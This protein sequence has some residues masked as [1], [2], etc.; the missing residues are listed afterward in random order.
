MSNV[1]KTG[2][3]SKAESSS[4][5]PAFSF[6]TKLAAGVCGLVLLTGAAAAWFSYRG[7]RA[8]TNALVHSMFREV[9]GH[10]V[11]HTRAFVMRAAPLAESLAQLADNGLAIHDS[12]LLANQLLA[13]LKGNP[14]LSWVSYGDED[15]TFTGVYRPIEGGLRIN[16]SRV[17]K[18]RTH[19]IEHDV[20]PDGTRPIANQEQDSG[21]DP[22]NRFMTMHLALCDSE[23]GMYRWVSAGHD[24]AILYDPTADA[25]EEIDA[26]DVPLGIMDDVEFT[27]YSYGPL[28]PGQI[29]F[30]GTDG[31]WE[32]PN[33]Q[34]EQFGKERLRQTL[35]EAKAEPAKRIAAILL[36]RLIVFRGEVSPVDDITYVI[37]KVESAPE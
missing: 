6:R 21:Y 35:R 31:V 11:T 7:A 3:P 34:G 16:Q 5:R 4:R 29:V 17:V 13:I 26:G 12:D 10:A 20:L 33:A 32:L 14:G 19:L 36:E 30:V 9:S 23:T 25:F 15:G 27:E 24:P 37:V 22:R 8:N 28:K 1:E 18:G 2:E